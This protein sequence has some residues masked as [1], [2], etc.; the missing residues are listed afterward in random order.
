MLTEAGKF[1]NNVT[2]MFDN[3]CNFSKIHKIII[4]ILISK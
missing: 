4:K 1:I 3:R 2:S